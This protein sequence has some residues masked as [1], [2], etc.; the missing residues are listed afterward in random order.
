M[1]LTGLPDTER[2]QA[3]SAL[4]GHDFSALLADPE[5]ASSTAVCPA[6]LFKYVGAGT[7]DADFLGKTMESLFMNKPTPPLSE[8]K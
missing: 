7:V 5:N 8:A 6:V 4:P 3:M 2:P 1:G